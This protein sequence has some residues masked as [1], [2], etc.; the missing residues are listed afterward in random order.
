MKVHEELR[1]EEKEEG[2]EKECDEAV[3]DPN[4]QDAGE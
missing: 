4:L 1:I 2:G 3:A